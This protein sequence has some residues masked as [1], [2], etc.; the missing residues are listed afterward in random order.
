MI[1]AACLGTAALYQGLMVRSYTIDTP[2]YRQGERLKLVVLSDLHSCPAGTIG[3]QLIQCVQQQK[4]DYILL[5]GDIIDDHY[6]PAPAWKLLRG[7]AAIA[8]TYYVPGNHEYRTRQMPR[9]LSNLHKCGVHVLMDQQ[10]L[11]AA[12]SASLLLCGWEDPEKFRMQNLQPA[13]SQAPNR[14]FSPIANQAAYSILLAHRPETIRDYLPLG[15]DLVVSGHAHGGQ[16]RIPYLINGVFAS[17]QGLFPRL[18]GGCYRYA[19]TTHIISRGL[20][21]YPYIPRIFNP[22]ELTVVTVQGMPHS[23]Y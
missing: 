14:P 11:I 2:K 13:R 12:N 16:V 8:P 22:P 3:T 15:F 20:V 18:A 1:G 9:I 5:P 23:P 10:I 19:N 17:G 4:P 7:L 21:V 6:P